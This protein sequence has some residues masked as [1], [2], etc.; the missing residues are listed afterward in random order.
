MKREWGKRVYFILDE[1]RKKSFTDHI[2]Y[3]EFSFKKLTV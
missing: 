1:I 3:K 2:I